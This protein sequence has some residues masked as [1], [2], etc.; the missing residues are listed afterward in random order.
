MDVP[1]M[2]ENKV[3]P[4]PVASAREK[5]AVTSVLDTAVIPGASRRRGSCCWR[6]G[7]GHGED[8]G[9]SRIKV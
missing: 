9:G 2:S 7:R 6:F 5:R 1:L 8:R 3:V 4:F